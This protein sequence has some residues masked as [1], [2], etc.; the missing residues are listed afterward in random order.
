MKQRIETQEQ[1]THNTVTQ[2]KGH[3]RQAT[4]KERIQ[5]T[6]NTGTKDT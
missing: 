2:E 4:Q 5:N 6:G 1:R 3:I